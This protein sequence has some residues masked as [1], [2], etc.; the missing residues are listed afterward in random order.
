MS[1]KD[2]ILSCADRPEPVPVDVPEWKAK[3][4][5]RVLTGTELNAY[6]SAA[7]R[8]GKQ[9]NFRA[10]FLVRAICNE[11]GERIFSDADV[12]KLGSRS[13]LV[14]DRLYDLARKLNRQ[15]PEAVEDAEKNLLSAPSGASGS[16]SPSPSA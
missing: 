1:L 12:A 13:G 7:Y 4:W 10:E 6:E 9:G 14:L 8:D 5:L 2:D 16:S 11:S 15:S 3:L